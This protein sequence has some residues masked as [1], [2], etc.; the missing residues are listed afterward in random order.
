M[1]HYFFDTNDGDML[2]ED[3][4]GLEFPDPESARRAAIA[5]LPDM[6]RDRLPDGDR[7]NFSVRVRDEAGTVL[8][9]ASLSLV[10]EWHILLAAK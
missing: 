3:D 8:Y 6:A 2:D 10:G 7:R 5:A 1:P 9:A 4:V